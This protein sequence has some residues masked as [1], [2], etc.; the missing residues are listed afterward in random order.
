MV[1][2]PQ[3]NNQ[4]EDDSIF[5]DNCG[6]RIA[7]ARAPLLPIASGEIQASISAIPP[8]VLVTIAG[9][10]TKTYTLTKDKIT[11]GRADDNDIMV[12]SHVVS[13]HHATLEKTPAGYEIVV[14]PDATNELT[15]QGLQVKQRKLLLDGDILRIDSVIPG[16]IVTFSYQAPSQ[17]IGRGGLTCQKCGTTAPLDAVFCIQCGASLSPA[18]S[19]PGAPEKHAPSPQVAAKT[20]PRSATQNTPCLVVQPD[21][22]SLPF[23][24]GKTEVIAGRKDPGSNNFP[25][26][27]LSP[28]M[29]DKGGISRRHA[30]FSLRG[31]HWQIEDLKSTNFTFLNKQKLQ[32]GQLYPLNNGDEVRLGQVTMTFFTS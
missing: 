30:K 26:V 31:D 6:A 11:I 14:S 22:T 27:D 17:A 1:T 28:Y 29:T 4:L 19:R 15:C 24:P 10:E 2:C 13:R 23:P 18:P 7:S 3:C 16:T 12:S 20:G 32:P 25:E 21:N 8:K 9:Q 5:C